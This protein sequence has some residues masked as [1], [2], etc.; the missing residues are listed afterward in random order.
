MLPAGYYYSARALK[1]S[2]VFARP[3]RTAPKCSLLARPL[4]D[5]GGAT[6]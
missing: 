1:G 5:G 6:A 4:N 3:G 2:D